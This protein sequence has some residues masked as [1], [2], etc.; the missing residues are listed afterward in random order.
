M[1]AS[2]S[3]RDRRAPSHRTVHDDPDGLWSGSVGLLTIADGLAPYAAT[4]PGVTDPRHRS[5]ALM[6]T[7]D[8]FEAWVIAW[9]AGGAVEL[10][11]HGD[12]AGAVVVV[13]GALVETTVTGGPDG[14]VGTVRDTIPTGGSVKFGPGHVHDIVNLGPVPAVSVHVYGPRLTLLPRG[15]E[16]AAGRTDGAVP[17]R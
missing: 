1:P 7:D 17:P 2:P 15:Q 4:W 9:P 10:H 5:W 14:T 11:D 8:T 16:Q 13:A 3:T 12:S 6:A